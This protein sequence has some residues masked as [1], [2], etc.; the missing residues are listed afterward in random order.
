MSRRKFLKNAASTFI[1]LNTPSL[2]TARTSDKSKS[3]RGELTNTQLEYDVIIIG[4]GAIGLASAYYLAKEHKNKKVLV[5]EQDHFFNDKTSSSGNSRQ[6]R[7]QYNEKEISEMVLSSI[8]LWDELQTHTN[9][10]IFKKAGCL[11]FGDEEVQGPEAQL[12]MVMKVMDELKIS[13]TPLNATQLEKDYG[14]SNFPADFKGF[15]QKDGASINVKTTLKT[16]YKMASQSSKITFAS[17]QKVIDIEN[18][19]N[20]VVVKTEKNIFSANKLIITAGPHTNDMLQLVGFNLDI[21]LWE[22]V[23]CYFAKKD[24]HIDYPTWITYQEIDQGSPGFYYGFPDTQ[25]DKP[26]YLRVAANYPSRLLNDMRGY[27]Q[28]PDPLVIKQTSDWVKRHMHGLDPTPL[29]T[30]TCINAMLS[31]KKNAQLN[32]KEFVV[33]FLPPS[34][35]HHKNIVIQGTGWVFKLVPL[36]GKICADLA[37]TGQTNYDISRVSVS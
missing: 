5:L 16:L 19:A 31:S 14:F 34:I 35:P 25:W 28:V 29:F 24:A 4:G 6:F 20:G 15:F 36:L 30:S 8:P 26:G 9:D 27:S 1:L 32:G 13:Y 21:D 2:L 23:S 3:E 22:M 7:I 33:G 10:E 11:W 17:Q 18:N 37:I 12:A